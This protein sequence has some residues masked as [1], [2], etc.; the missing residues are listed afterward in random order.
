LLG[1][2]VARHAHSR[3]TTVATGWRDDRAFGESMDLLA[4]VEGLPDAEL[5]GLLLAWH[6][7]YGRAPE[8]LGDSL[9]LRLPLAVDALPSPGLQELAHLDRHLPL[10]GIVAEHD[11]IEQWF[12]YRDPAQARTVA[13]RLRKALLA[14]PGAQV[15]VGSPRHRDLD[16]WEVLNFAGGIAPALAA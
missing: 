16:C 15:R 14:V 1:E 6:R 8:V 11:W 13:G 12:R 10:L 2:A 3:V 9:A 5:A 7:R 4:L